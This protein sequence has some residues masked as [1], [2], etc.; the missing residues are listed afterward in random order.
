MIIYCKYVPKSCM[1]LLHNFIKKILHSWVI[2]AVHL[3][4]LV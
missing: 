2:T 1:E 4:R 3:H